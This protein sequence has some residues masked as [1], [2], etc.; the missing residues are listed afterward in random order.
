MTTV[1]LHTHELGSGPPAVL[2]HG[3]PETSYAWRGVAPALAAAGVRVVSPDLRGYGRSP[4]PAGVRNYTTEAL[5]GDIE[6]LLEQCGPGVVLVGHDWGGAIAWRVGMRRPDLL[7]R[8]VILNA[9][10]PATMRRELSRPSPQILR[11]WY[12]GA[13]QLPWVPEGI[14][15]A[16]D[17]AI[18]RRALRSGPAAGDP[19]AENVYLDAFRPDGALTAALDYYRA[20]L[21][22]PPP[23]PTV[24]GVPTLVIWGMRDRY[25]SPR[26]L[27]G[28][29]SWVTDL[30]IERLPEASH[31]L[32]HEEPGRVAGLIADFMRDSVEPRQAD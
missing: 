2:L 22:H 11:S 27:E 8:L 6:A 12:A 29:D 32:H 21:R 24:I 17:F 4:R 15:R 30:R 3:F 23:P 20:A 16:G 14:L 13:F 25:L 7:R 18:L 28:L 1:R 26:L 9:P 19:A 5:A 31:W 10:H